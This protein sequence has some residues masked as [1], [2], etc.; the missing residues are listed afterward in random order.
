MK[1]FLF[2][3]FVLFYIIV[4]KITYADYNDSVREYARKYGISQKQKKKRLQ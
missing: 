2:V 4:P 1:K 3:L